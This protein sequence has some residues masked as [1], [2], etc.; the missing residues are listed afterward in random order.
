M[1]VGTV[2]NFLSSCSRIFWEGYE[3]IQFF[4]FMFSL[5][6]FNLIVDKSLKAKTKLKREKKSGSTVKITTTRPT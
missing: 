5:F 4:Y 6:F 2:S 3:S 1:F